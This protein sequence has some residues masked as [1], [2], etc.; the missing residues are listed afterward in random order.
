MSFCPKTPKL[1]VRKF[2]KLRLLEL[3]KPITL[4]EDLW[5]R[6]GLKQSCS[7]YWELSND[8]WHATYTQI[9]QGD[10]RLLVVGSQ[11][12]NLTLDPSFGHNL[13]FKCPNGSCKHILDIYIQRDFQAMWRNFQSNEFW[14]LKLPF[15]D[16]EV[17][18]DSNSQSG[19]AFGSVGVCSLTLSY[20]FKSMKCDSRA[21]LL[22]RTFASPCLGH[23]PKARVAIIW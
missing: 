21:S 1:G 3:C 4:C 15:E 11:I 20:T 14:P 17:H 16:L 2:P 7:P 8:M 13:C 5:L 9:N 23:E 12:G 19:N 10:S 18:R 22:A 6:W